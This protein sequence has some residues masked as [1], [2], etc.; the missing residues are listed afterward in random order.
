MDQSEMCFTKAS[1]NRIGFSVPILSSRL[2]I[3][4]YL[5]DI[6]VMCCMFK[7]TKNKS[8]V[9]TFFSTFVGDNGS[10]F[11]DCRYVQHVENYA[12]N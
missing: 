4:S 7:T 8:F 1:M 6:L 5:R 10:F 11:T 9:Q 12:S 3:Y 2:L